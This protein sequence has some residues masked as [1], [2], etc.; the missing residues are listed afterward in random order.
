M[1]CTKQLMA[2]GSSMYCRVQAVHHV[3]RKASLREH[4]VENILGLVAVRLER[5]LAG[6]R[7][8]IL[9]A[10]EHKLLVA[11]RRAHDDAQQL[12]ALV[13]SGGIVRLRV[14]D[15]LA[16]LVEERTVRL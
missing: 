6:W 3:I 1:D 5:G 10:L 14:D 15:S 7:E 2:G 16:L 9:E 4:R 11:K 8:Q 12:V 13:D